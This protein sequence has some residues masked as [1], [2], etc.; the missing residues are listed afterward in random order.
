MTLAG[1][2]AIPKAPSQW[3]SHLYDFVTGTKGSFVRLP[4]PLGEYRLAYSDAD[5]PE[6]LAANA[7]AGWYDAHFQAE[8]LYSK[9][10]QIG[11]VKK[12]D[13]ELCFDAWHV[14]TLLD[15]PKAP[16]ELLVVRPDRSLGS[17]GSA[18]ILGR[19]ETCDRAA[20][21]FLDKAEGPYLIHRFEPGT[22]IFVNGVM[23]NGRLKSTDIWRCFTLV[24]GCR[25]VLVGVV[26]ISLADLLADLPTRLE[27]LARGLGL[28]NAPVHF[29]LVLTSRGPRLVKCAARLA[30]DP[31]PAL[32]VL[33]GTPGQ[34]ERVFE[35]FTGQT[36]PYLTRRQCHSADYSFVFTR[37][38]RIQGFWNT[39]QIRA[40]PGFSHFHLEP[41]IGGF[42]QPTGDG[43]SYAATAF[44]A[45]EDKAVLL[46]SIARLNALNIAG[47][48]ELEDAGQACTQPILSLS[49]LRE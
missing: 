25:P 44:L 38:G 2:A 33:R 9:T 31:L 41:N 19:G 43:Y 37:T 15:L 34:I 40:V 35:V 20:L 49:Q 24:I 23:T 1:A 5:Q 46:Q 22:P 17:R 18:V 3:Q 14:E 7:R 36:L 28:R 13:H 12:I 11:A 16:T 21:A 47:A 39:D 32:C 42:S 30:T 48:L 27:K 26:D 6:H 4:G 45:H 29:E 8:A 10:A